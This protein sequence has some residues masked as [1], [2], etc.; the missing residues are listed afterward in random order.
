[1]NKFSF[2]AALLFGVLSFYS[3]NLS[4]QKHN[5]YKFIEPN[6]SVSYDSNY[7]KIEKRY[8]NTYYE[9]EA[10]DFFSSLTLQKKQPFILK[11]VTQ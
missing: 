11:Q 5:A 6:I 7:F 3:A 9:T 1:M 8:S 2:L 4:A 10:Y